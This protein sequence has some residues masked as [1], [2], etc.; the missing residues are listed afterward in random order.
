MFILRCRTGIN[1]PENQT[2][3][4]EILLMTM[5]IEVSRPTEDSQL[6]SWEAA[7]QAGLQICFLADKKRGWWWYHYTWWKCKR[8]LRDRG[9]QI[10]E[11]TFWT[12]WSRVWKKIGCHRVRI[13]EPFPSASQK[14]PQAPRLAGSRTH[15]GCQ[16]SGCTACHM[17]AETCFPNLMQACRVLFLE[18]ILSSSQELQ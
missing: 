16:N 10:W 9:V 18:S 11:Q 2:P 7:A 14:L 5:N 6:C 4:P 12:C 17:L 1:I 13:L 15:V 3:E 8:F